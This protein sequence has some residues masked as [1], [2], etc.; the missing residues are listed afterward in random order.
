METM[1]RQE[2]V[3]LCLEVLED[4]KGNRLSDEVNA[5]LVQAETHIRDY[6]GDTLRDPPEKPY[7]ITIKLEYLGVSDVGR[8]VTWSVDDL[9]CPSTSRKHTQHATVRDGV[10][11]TDRPASLQ[12]TFPLERMRDHGETDEG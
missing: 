12:T 8:A 11:V 10:I 2:K 9:K 7:V 5:R 3:E 4:S 1:G 6:M